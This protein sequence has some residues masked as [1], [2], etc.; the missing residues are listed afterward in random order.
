MHTS[1]LPSITLSPRVAA[2]SA[3]VLGLLAPSV[4]AAQNATPEAALT[5]LRQ[6]LRVVSSTNVDGDGDGD[7][8]RLVL[9][10]EG[11][12]VNHCVVTIHTATGWVSRAAVGLGGDRA[13]RCVG[14]ASGR[15]VIA[16]MSPGA[17]DTPSVVVFAARVTEA[18]VTLGRAVHTTALAVTEY[19]HLTAVAAGRQIAVEAPNHRRVAAITP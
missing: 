19:E 2:L 14:V 9:V 7:E 12:E 13:D 3:C 16:Q 10:D 18:A 1:K 6:G 4:A 5:A 8:D 17:D 15:L 11:V